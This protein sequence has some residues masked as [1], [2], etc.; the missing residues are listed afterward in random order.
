VQRLLIR[1]C[2]G[3]TALLLA[4]GAARAD[5]LIHNLSTSATSPLP[6][7]SCLYIDQGPGTDAKLCSGYAAALGALAASNFPSSG[8]SG[9]VATVNTNGSY[10]DSGTLL[11]SLAPKASPTLSGTVTFPDASTLTSS[12]LSGLVSLGVTN[13]SANTTGLTFSGGSH[14]GSDA[15]S[16]ASIATTLNTTG[17]P[18][19]F[20]IAVTNT[21]AGASTR[22]FHI[23]GGAAGATDEFSVDLSGTLYGSTNSNM[24]SLNTVSF[25]NSIIVP[26]LVGIGGSFLINS[27]NTAVGLSIGS[28][29]PLSFSSNSTVT[30]YSNLGTVDAQIFRDA[31]GVLGQRHSTTAQALRVYN[32]YTSSTSYEAAEIDWQ[33]TSN[34]LSI[35]TI[36]GSGGGSVRNLQFLVGGADQLDYGVTAASAWTM[37]GLVYLTGIGVTPTGKQPLCIDTSTKELYYGSSGSC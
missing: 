22:A 24:F 9:D 5:S 36:K 10:S 11:S 13:P 18:D 35:G 4:A 23:Y 30:N 3:L 37:A 28:G 29:F 26:G 16:D 27:S 12:G 32:T 8:T 1:L 2:A 34:V 20:K 7:E 33:G 19:V 17:S 15:H 14:T 31:A 21:A 25:N 6:S